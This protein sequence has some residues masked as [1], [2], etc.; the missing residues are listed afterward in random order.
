MTAAII[1]KVDSEGY[2][3]S[4]K[5]VMTVYPSFLTQ[6]RSHQC[7]ILCSLRIF[8]NR[9]LAVACP[10]LGFIFS[11]RLVGV[12]T[13]EAVGGRGA[14]G[15]RVS[16]SILS[17]DPASRASS[18]ESK[19]SEVPCIGIDSSEEPSSDGKRQ[20]DFEQFLQ[21]IMYYR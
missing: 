13:R 16:K 21:L 15:G 19:G 4:D 17:E 12:G 7:P 10:F 20:F 2:A 6:H 14:V 5:T 18:S 1:Q 11:I 3:G 9:C 8:P